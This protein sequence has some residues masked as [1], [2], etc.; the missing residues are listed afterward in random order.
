MGDGVDGGHGCC[1][2]NPTGWSGGVNGGRGDNIWT[3]CNRQDLVLT[4]SSY[5]W[6]C[7]SFQVKNVSHNHKSNNYSCNDNK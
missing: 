2:N 4:D 6:G 5:S 1:S 3:A 7:K